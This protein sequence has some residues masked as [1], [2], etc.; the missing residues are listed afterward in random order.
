[1]QPCLVCQSPGPHGFHFGVISCRACAAFFRRAAFSKWNSLKCKS[2]MCNMNLNYCK[3]CRLQKCYAVGME[4]SNFQYHRDSL[5]NTKNTIMISRK[6]EIPKSFQSFVG[7]PEMILF[8]DSEKSTTNKTYVDVNFLIEG[9]TEI[10]RQP[11]EMVHLTE[12]RLKRL[13]VGMNSVRG[14]NQKYQLV[15]TISQKEISSMWQFYFITVAKWLMH[16]T[17]FEKL[18]MEVKLTILQT[19]WHVWQNLD[20]RSLMAFHQKNNPNF[21]KHHTISRTGVLLDK[22]NVHFDA[23]WLSDYPSREVGGFLRVPGNDNITE[24]LKSLDPTDI[25]L[26]FMLA[27]LSFEYAGKRCQGK[28][29]ETLEHFQNLLADDI[30]QY[31]TKELRIDNYFDRLAKLMKINNSIQKKIWEARPRME[32]A[33]VFN[34]I[35]LDFSHPEMFIDSGYN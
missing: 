2:K 11:M 21:P 22:A 6:S 13:A 5:H 9:A 3:P 10:F 28:I 33:K 25:E 18:D 34:L 12:N 19:V 14:K 29:L 27:Q 26:T 15:T 23:S 31:Y 20:H 16:F 32:L 35:K 17:E 4:T 8:W 7:R 1:M 24:K 30:H